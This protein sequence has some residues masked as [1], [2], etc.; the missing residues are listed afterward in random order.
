MS[1]MLDDIEKYGKELVLKEDK[2][3]KKDDIDLSELME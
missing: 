1:N 2:Q 3:S